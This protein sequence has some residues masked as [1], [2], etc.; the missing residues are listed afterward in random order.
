MKYA[1][2]QKNKEVYKEIHKEFKKTVKTISSK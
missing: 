2:R 1:L